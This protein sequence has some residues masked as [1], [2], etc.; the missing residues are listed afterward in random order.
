[1]FK[2]ALRS[3]ISIFSIITALA[4]L[5]SSY[6]GNTPPGGRRLEDDR[7]RHPQLKPVTDPDLKRI[8]TPIPPTL[9]ARLP[10]T[11][12]EG[13]PNKYTKEDPQTDSPL[14]SL[15]APVIQLVL[16]N[17]DPENTKNVALSCKAFRRLIWAGKD[18][19][20]N[21]WGT[22][23]AHPGLLKQYI[24]HPHN[25]LA[26][27]NDLATLYFPSFKPV[28]P[29]DDQVD[30]QLPT[31][32]PLEKEEDADNP[33]KTNVVPELVEEFSRLV[34]THPEYHSFL[35]RL[36]VNLDPIHDFEKVCLASY[37]VKQTPNL[38]YLL[39]KCFQ[40]TQFDP[41]HFLKLIQDPENHSKLRMNLMALKL[42]RLSG[43]P[44]AQDCS[45]ILVDMIREELQ[46]F[47]ETAH[48]GSRNAFKKKW[49]IVMN[50]ITDLRWVGFFN[51][52]ALTDTYSNVLLFLLSCQILG[53]NTLDPIIMDK[54]RTYSQYFIPS[55]SNAINEN[56]TYALKS[57]HFCR[58][59]QVNQEKIILEQ[60]DAIDPK[61]LEQV[62][63]KTRELIDDEKHETAISM[64]EKALA[65]A[66]GNDIRFKLQI[67]FIECVLWTNNKEKLS[68]VKTYMNA[69][70]EERKKKNFYNLAVALLLYEGK[71]AD[72]HA[73]LPKLRIS[74]VA[75]DPLLIAVGE[76]LDNP[77]LP[78][79]LLELLR[80]KYSA[81]FSNAESKL[82]LSINEGVKKRVLETHDKIG[83]IFMK[84]FE[85]HP[86]DL[87][88]YL[89]FVA[90]AKSSQIQP[91][92][93]C[94][95][96]DKMP[97]ASSPLDTQNKHK[98]DKCIIA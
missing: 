38:L 21:A 95:S 93:N 46:D 3:S 19:L 34:H 10:I 54:F 5:N 27:H 71:F 83:H 58:G 23:K 82:I 51:D 68:Q 12:T 26:V 84:L 13:N 57:I 80:K 28:I 65:H 96:D 6:A 50:L 55:H 42:L 17:L 1:M 56:L 86:V 89:D 24:S 4:S 41:N 37:I 94:V 9:K 75:T 35:T 64:L 88:N 33:L 8:L 48:S 7:S 53:H 81:I 25:M 18:Y 43:N 60:L 92:K 40:A 98:K 39:F 30:F 78:K 97:D 36:Y 20:I 47:E 74:D 79:K 67:R 91:V 87:R 16:W 72:V 85:K 11:Y 52:E 61:N 63:H 70:P 32:V 22:N 14:N 62:Y 31:I 49:P 69:F 15:P 29:I 76:Q 77:K 44:H 90:I 66:D 45:Q 2:R 59:D 73:L